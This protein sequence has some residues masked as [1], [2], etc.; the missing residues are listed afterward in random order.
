MA[1]GV[2]PVRSCEAFGV[3]GD[4]ESSSLDLL[5]TSNQRTNGAHCH[6]AG[7]AVGKRGI[8]M[9]SRAVTTQKRRGE[10]EKVATRVHIA[11][12]L[13]GRNEIGYWRHTAHEVSAEMERLTPTIASM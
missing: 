10:G 13:L 11:S 4:G 7:K 5:L 8:K 2:L 12:H 1:F 9:T 3:C 6:A